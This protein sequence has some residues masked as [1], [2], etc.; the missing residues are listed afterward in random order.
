[1]KRDKI[2]T[3]WFEAN[4]RGY[5]GTEEE[6]QGYY[7]AYLL[8]KQSKKKAKSDVD[9]SYKQCIDFWLKEFH[10]DFTFGGQQGKAMKS[11]I[12]KIKTLCQGRNMEGTTEQ[13]VASFKKMCLNFPEWYKDKD[14]QVI[15]SKFNEIIHQI[16]T[17]KKNDNF[18]SKNSA[19]RFS[20]FAG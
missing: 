6:A 4:P 7:E 11:I 12:K 14:L 18:H 20:E 10:K 1:M 17:G 19:Q 15:D 16:S 2:F 5:Y 3:E 9:E 8:G 13:I